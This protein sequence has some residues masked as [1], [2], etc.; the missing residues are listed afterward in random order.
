M[1]SRGNSVQVSVVIPTYNRAGVVEE[2]IASALGQ[3]HRDL[4]VI[5]E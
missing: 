5:V 2:A 1:A 3:T 4:E